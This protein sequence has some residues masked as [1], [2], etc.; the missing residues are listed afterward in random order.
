MNTPAQKLAVQLA[1]SHQGNTSP[2]PSVGAVIVKNGQIIGQGATEPAGGKHA[3]IVAIESCS[4]DIAGGDMYVTLEPCCHH[5]K[6]GPCTEAIIQS[7]IQNVFIGYTDPNPLVSGQGV[8]KLEEAGI[9]VAKWDDETECTK[10]YE[11]F[12]KYI[13]TKQPFVTAKFAM[14][15]DG[16]ICTRSGDS[17]WI[18]GP[19]S[20]SIVHDIRR[21]SDAILTGI[22]TV[23]ADNPSLTARDYTDKPWTDRQPTRIITDSKLQMEHN[24]NLQILNQVGHTII[25]TTTQPPTTPI[26]DSVTVRTFTPDN[27]DR[28]DLSLLL[29]ELGKLGFVHVLVEG[30]STLLGSLFDQNLV[31]KVLAFISPI[32]IGGDDAKSPIGGS[33]VEFIS[34]SLHLKKTEVS[35]SG[36]DILVTGY[37]N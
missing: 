16:K 30:G 32:I 31:D 13:A 36:N 33:G 21:K 35:Y 19:E 3:E 17:K 2:N 29:N 37:I 22:G 1:I 11:G 9:K 5:G 27:N 14:S 18:S 7:G 6:T 8:V 10:L 28:V 20:R 25:A 23:L 15:L 34:E 4:I 12:R 26:S 24:L